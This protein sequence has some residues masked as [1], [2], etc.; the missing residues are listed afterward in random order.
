MCKWSK[1]R[2]ERGEKGKPKIR[3]EEECV[4]DAR[5]GRAKGSGNARTRKWRGG[6]VL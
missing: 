5:E 1:W 6:K 3:R 2:K 4:A